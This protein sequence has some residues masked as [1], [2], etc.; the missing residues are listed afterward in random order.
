MSEA[1]V[2]LQLQNQA[3]PQ[4]QQ[5][6]QDAQ[7]L[8]AAESRLALAA[9]DLAGA[10][11]GMDA[12]LGKTTQ[13]TQQ[14]AAATLT[15]TRAE[16]AHAVALGD[17]RRAIELLE[18]AITAENAETAE[19]FR[20]ATQITQLENQITAATQREADATVRL[21][22]EQ[23]RAAA[24]TNDYAGALELLN[25]AKLQSNGASAQTVAALD[26]QI[27]TT[28]AAGTATGVLGAQVAALANPMVIATAA[29]GAAVTV[30]SSFSDA[31]HF[32][33][34]LQEERTAF[35]GI[36]GDFA[37]GN[38]ILDEADKRLHAYGFTTKQTTD[39][40]DELA[41][42]IRESTS[43]TRDQ[44][45]AL[46]RISVL[47]PADPVKALS[48]AVEGIQTGNI[49]ALSKELGLTKDEQASLKQSTDQG[50]DAFI[51]L[52]EV[53]DKHGITLAVARERMQG[54]AGAEREAAQ[55]AEELTKAEAAYAAGP[56][57]VF[58]EAKTLALNALTDSLGTGTKS[59][60]G[61]TGAV[62]V[63]IT[64]LLF[65]RKATDDLSTAHTQNGHDLVTLLG[66]TAGVTVATKQFSGAVA[67]VGNDLRQT[68]TTTASSTAAQLGYANALELGGVQARAAALANQQKADSDKLASVDAQTHAIA[69]KQVDDAARAAADAMFASGKAGAQA[70]ALLA[71]S[72]SLIDQR[73]SAYYRLEAAT[74]AANQAE[75][76]KSVT[77]A[78]TTERFFGGGGSRGDSSDTASDTA[79]NVAA[80]KTQNT[81]SEKTLDS[82]IALAAAKGQTAKQIDL[83]RQKEQLFGKDAADRTTIEAQIISIQEKGGKS[84]ETS[85]NKQLSTHESIYDSINKQKDALLDIEELTIKD[86]QTDRD[87]AQ[88]VKTANAIIA[89]LA[90]RTDDRANDLR[91]RAQDAI[92]LASVQ[93]RQRAQQ[94]AEKGAT[95]GGT[96]GPNG[97]LLQSVPGGGAPP[98]PGGAPPFNAPPPPPPGGTTAAGALGA[99]IQL[100]VDGKVLATV[101]EPFLMD[102]LIKAARGQRAQVGG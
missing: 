101:V 26:T 102:A 65:A 11:R 59:M 92:A 95:A 76:A 42:I 74:F 32:A 12:A 62:G 93:D 2:T 55:A 66:I 80:L 9:G 63:E 16:A 19:G 83:L 47:K 31:I 57:L 89:G 78:I 29:I 35:G 54:Q 56:G 8:A 72:S 45:E 60:G 18:G 88:K 53:L 3:S 20:L 44:A 50:K 69:E 79:A 25:T 13:D 75:N 71:S 22:Q 99:T 85:L 58:T 24:A 39:A 23:A 96:I 7:A 33:G 61:F 14:S 52:N 87:D 77:K 30:V 97:K 1:V 46:A 43:T 73:T 40:F 10:H 34:Q 70:A 15:A 38:S 41:P 4:L 86:R 64:Q 49:R 17:K 67:G 48:T 37:K 94:L 81:A 6:T 5:T 100:V 90:G 84:R 91:G 27:A 82:E 98:G 36:I 21:L 68:A 51:A 28:E